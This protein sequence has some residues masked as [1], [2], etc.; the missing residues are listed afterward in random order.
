MSLDSKRLNDMTTL[1]RTWTSY[2][3]EVVPRGAS[4]TQVEETRRAFYAG[5]HAVLCILTQELVEMTD[6]DSAE[7]LSRMLVEAAGI[8]DDLGAS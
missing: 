5:A 4:P 1:F 6:D 3:D 7:A 8:V 2:L